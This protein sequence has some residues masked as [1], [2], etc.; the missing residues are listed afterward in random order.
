M[1]SSANILTNHS[2][3]ETLSHIEQ[4]SNWMEAAVPNPNAQNQAVQF[5]V[6]LE[7]IHEMLEAVSPAGLTPSALDQ[8]TFMKDVLGYMQKQIKTGEIGISFERIDRLALLDSLCD[9]I[10][11]AI[12]IAHMLGMDINGALREVANSNDSK[13][14]EDGKP[15][16]NEHKKIMKGPLYTPPNLSPYL[17][18]GAREG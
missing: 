15:I 16:F 11:T 10:V 18:K 9:Q 13:F 2:T 7:E 4:I 8:L 1:A 6:H 5:G 12:G 17:D 3:S 14:G